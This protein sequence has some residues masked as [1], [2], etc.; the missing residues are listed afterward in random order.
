M[1]LRRVLLAIAPLGALALHPSGI[2]CS[3]CRP[4]PLVAPPRPAL[5]AE[6]SR[7]LGARAPRRRA[8]AP[9]CSEEAQEITLYPRRWLQLA[10]LSSLALLSDWVC[11]SVA[12]APETW[13]ATYAHDPATLIDVFLLT[14]VVFCFIEPTVVGRFGLRAV[15]IT[16]ATV[17]ALGCA[18]RS[19]LPF[20]GAAPPYAEVRIP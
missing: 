8:G 4:Q 3:H 13:E 20:T 7:A 14:N 12:A 19:G 6:V 17:M 1:A 10:Y 9:R 15:V 18:L 5:V 16:A 11:F 2:Y